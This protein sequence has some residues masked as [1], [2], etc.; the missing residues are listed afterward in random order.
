MITDLIPSTIVEIAVLIASVIDLTL[1][2]NYL[3]IYREKFPKKDFVVI[4]ANPLIRFCIRS[5]GLGE[6]IFRSAF[7]ILPLLVLL[8]YFLPTN[9]DFFLAGTFYMMLTFHLTNLLALKR[10]RMIRE[11]S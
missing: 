4:E 8:L 6:G 2:Y 1:T 5:C 10:I 7:I 11:V 9:W 3:K